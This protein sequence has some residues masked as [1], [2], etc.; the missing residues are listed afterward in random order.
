MSCYRNNF[1]TSSRLHIQHGTCNW[2]Y[3]SR[4][5]EVWKLSSYSLNRDSSVQHLSAVTGAAIIG[6]H[7]LP[8]PEGIPQGS[9]GHQ[10]SPYLIS[11]QEQIGTTCFQE[12]DSTFLLLQCFLCHTQAVA[13]VQGF[14]EQN[15][16][17]DRE[18]HC[19]SSRGSSIS[20]TLRTR[21][22]NIMGRA[23]RVHGC[24]E[25][26]LLRAGGPEQHIFVL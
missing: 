10:N 11:V 23:E 3:S 17:I 14:Q 12:N 16:N 26:E 6:N 18:Q 9:D 15:A 4:T 22:Q 13:R 7:N 20:A 24:N 5:Y 1:Y 25:M 21:L 2:I 8:Q 19:T